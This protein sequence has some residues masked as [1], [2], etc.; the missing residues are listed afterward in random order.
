MADIRHFDRYQV[1]KR[2]FVSAAGVA[3]SAGTAFCCLRF[4]SYHSFF[5]VFYQANLSLALLN[6]LP[7]W[8]L[9]GARVISSLFSYLGLEDRIR[10]LLSY[11]TILLGAAF[12]FLGLAGIWMGVFNPGL[13]VMGPYL[14]YAAKAEG[15]SD[16]VRRL[17]AFGHP[18]GADDVVKTDVWT[19]SE[20][21]SAYALVSALAQGSRQRHQIVVT[22]DPDS[23]KATGCHTQKQL[24]DMV[25]ASDR[26]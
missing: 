21:C 4:A 6:L 14:C 20:G 12:V 2:M 5:R 13:L 17:E 7:A 19:A 11:L 18:I 25:V 10:K 1:W 22:I 3:V 16:R 15:V 8:P 9:D 26:D 23:G 24:L